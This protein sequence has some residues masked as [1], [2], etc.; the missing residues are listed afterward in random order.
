VGDYHDRVLLYRPEARDI[1]LLAPYPC[2]EL[3]PWLEMPDSK[4]IYTQQNCVI[5]SKVHIRPKLLYI[6][7]VFFVF[8]RNLVKSGLPRRRRPQQPRAVSP[9]SDPEKKRATETTASKRFRTKSQKTSETEIESRNIYPVLNVPRILLSRS[10]ECDHDITRG[11]LN[12]EVPPEDGRRRRRL[13]S[14]PLRRRRGDRDSLL[15][16]RGR[17][18]RQQLEGSIFQC[19]IWRVRSKQGDPTTTSLYY[20]TYFS[21]H[22]LI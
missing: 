17:R 19:Q 18:L 7:R 2:I 1:V 14:P 5:V 4:N 6:K 16:L 9:K 20:H 3:R 8:S 15:A 21:H 10:L 11:E 13:H 22:V 12:M